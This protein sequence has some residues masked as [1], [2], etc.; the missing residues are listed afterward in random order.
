MR[1]EQAAFAWASSG[2]ESK[3]TLAAYLKAIEMMLLEPKSKQED[4]QPLLDG[5]FIDMTGSKA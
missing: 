4:F 5:K 1:R 2:T 3:N